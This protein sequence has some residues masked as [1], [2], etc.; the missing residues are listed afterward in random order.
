MNEDVPQGSLAEVIR[1]SVENVA[2][3]S[4][5]DVQ[6]LHVPSGNLRV[7]HEVRAKRDRASKCDEA[8]RAVGGA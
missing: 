1:S 3:P 6:P 4:L 8:L 5:D 7:R 2:Q